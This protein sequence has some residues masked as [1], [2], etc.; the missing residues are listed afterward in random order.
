MPLSVRP[1]RWYGVLLLVAVLTAAAG[2]AHEPA[3]R[4][5]LATTVPV[6]TVRALREE[7]DVELLEPAPVPPVPGESANSK[8]PP[9][10]EPAPS[11]A[12][13]I[14]HPPAELLGIIQDGTVPLPDIAPPPELLPPPPGVAAPPAEIAPP[15]DEVAPRPSGSF[16]AGTFLPDPFDELAAP[17]L[18]S[19]PYYPGGPD[20][21]LIA[22][23]DGRPTF[24]ADAKMFL[25][26]IWTDHTHYYSLR[27]GLPLLAGFGV[28]AALANTHA[29]M[30]FREQYQD[31]V[32]NSI[33]NHWHQ[34]IH[35]PK[36]LGNGEY[37]IP[38][39][40]GAL[41]IGRSFQE[42]PAGSVMAEWGGRSVRTLL[43]GAPP[44]L[45]AQTLTGGSR[46]TETHD[47]SRWHP[48]HDNNGVSGHAF[49]GAIPFLSAAKMTDNIWLK[50]AFYAGSVL[51]GVSRINDDGHFLSQVFLGW[52]MAYWAASAVDQTQH[53]S[54]VQ[55]VPVSVAGSTGIGLLWEF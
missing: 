32:R 11:V 15:P 44:M 6:R 47:G 19:T 3:G 10:G 16:N 12:P 37:T 38:V 35:A 27:N 8:S 29:D 50:S 31:N 48:L 49:M 24:R 54:A 14:P 7:G 26:R 40:A 33:E 46:P 23:F 36:M 18:P 25:G 30:G 39:F 43:V 53:D 17:P 52:W 45:V 42:Y 28:G 41:F 4:L 13:D 55:I 34:A 5:A 2:C 20:P 1:L 22:P 9:P 51:P 21:A